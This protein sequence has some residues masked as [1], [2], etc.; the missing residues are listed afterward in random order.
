[1]IEEDIKEAISGFENVAKLEQK[2]GKW[3]FKALKK[4]T[5]LYLQT[6]E[7]QKVVEKFKQLMEYTKSAVTANYAEKGLDSVLDNVGMNKDV[8]LAEEL[9][10]AALSALQAQKNERAWFRTNLK[11]GKLL[12]DSREFGKL[13]KVFSF[14]FFLELKRIDK[15]N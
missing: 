3:G 13:S 2:K 1:M 14:F 11:L 8:A 10:S 5:K 12:F 9:Y 7:K 6:G 15:K 4:L